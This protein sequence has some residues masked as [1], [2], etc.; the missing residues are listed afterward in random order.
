MIF[1]GIA[2]AL[3]TPFKNGKIDVEAF[4]KILDYQYDNCVD[5]VV[6]L[7]TTGEPATMSQEEKDLVITLAVKRL[8]GKIPIIVGAGSN[9]TESAISACKNAEKLGADGLLVVTPYY[10]KCTQE[11]LVAHYGEIAKSTSLPIICYNVPSRTGVNM[12]P[13]TFAKLASEYDNIVA[14]KEASG[15]MEQIEQYLR[16]VRGKAH[17]YSGDDAL[18]VPITA[19]GGS[20]VISVASNVFPAYLQNGAPCAG[21]R[22][23]KSVKNATRRTSLNIRALLRG[24]P[25]PRKKGNAITRML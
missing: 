6:V 9:C 25:D 4:Q 13:Q 24:K 20:G 14:V 2:T 19:M 1:K 12:L 22:Y 8:K 17:V 11:G 5:A 16:L 10:N 15:N 21:R 18:T 23:Q 3:I 7:G